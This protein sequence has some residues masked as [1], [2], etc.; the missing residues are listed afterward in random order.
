VRKRRRARCIARP[1][2]NRVWTEN[3]AMGRFARLEET[4]TRALFLRSPAASHVT[5]TALVADG[6]YTTH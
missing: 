4:A 6:G 3:A 2:W 1:A 5:G